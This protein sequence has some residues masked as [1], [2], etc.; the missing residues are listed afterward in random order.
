MKTSPVLQLFPVHQGNDKFDV[1]IKNHKNGNQYKH[2]ENNIWVRNFTLNYN[3]PVDINKLFD[4]KEISTFI[5]NENKNIFSKFPKFEPKDLSQKNIIITSDGFGFEKINEVLNGINLN[6]KFIILT[7][8]SL[9]KW[10][11]L[12]VLPDL[13]VENNPFK[14]ALN[15]ISYKYYPNCLISTR[16]F[17]Q[18]VNNYK[19]KNINLY[20]PTPLEFYNPITK[21]D[22]SKYLDDY[23]NPICAAINYSYL[24][25]AKNI[26]F[27]YCSEAFEEEKPATILHNDGIHYQ[28]Q[29]NKLSEKIIDSMI[30]WI[31]KNNKSCNVFYHGLDKTFKFASY[32]EKEDLIK[33]LKL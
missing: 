28:Y 29:Q 3:K 30:F 32:I 31:R 12:K 2:V 23:R 21:I 15:N 9:K 18:F 26:F 20:N 22:D 17:Y 27:L 11:N 4:E 16:T 24:C 1:I 19:Y 25:N 8:N 6:K 5:F 33:I 7:N 13:F 14:E 10:D